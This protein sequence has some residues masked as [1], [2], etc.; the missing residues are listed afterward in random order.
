MALYAMKQAHAPVRL[1]LED[2]S[3]CCQ[4]RKFEA[5]WFITTEET[6]T[7]TAEIEAFDCATGKKLFCAESAGTFAAGT[8]SL[9]RFEDE[10]PEGITAVFFYVNGEYSGVRLYGVPDYKTAFSLPQAK[11]SVSC[12]EN[13]VML[14]NA[15]EN[16]AVNL[17][18][19][20]P[21]AADKTVIFSDNYITLAPGQ[22]RTVSFT[23]AEANAEI[24][25][26]GWNL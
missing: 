12:K 22:K 3:W 17:R 11:V 1:S 19:E 13:T 4:D 25:V 2:R 5:E 23:G 15:G 21:G 24:R 10:L 9:K 16:V 7:G 6:F 14:E 26:T 18:L 20:I 8:H